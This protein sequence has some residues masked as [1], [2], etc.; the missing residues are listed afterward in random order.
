MSDADAE[1]K[2]G[3][4]DPEAAQLMEKKEEAME[5]EGMN[6]A[7][8]DEVKDKLKDGAFMCCCCLCECTNTKTKILE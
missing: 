7:E 3:A 2:S 6:D 4:G 1:K 5:A 8:V